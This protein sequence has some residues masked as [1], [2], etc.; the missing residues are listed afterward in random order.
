MGLRMKLQSLNFMAYL[1]YL[2]A[3]GFFIA[4]SSWQ[5]SSTV[6]G[7]TRKILASVCGNAGDAPRL[8]KCPTE[9][10]RERERDSIL[11]RSQNQNKRKIGCLSKI[12]LNESTLT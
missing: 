8:Q 5:F 1:A 4:R 9:R 3:E 6:V 2:R 10:E 12:N 11:Q 7:T